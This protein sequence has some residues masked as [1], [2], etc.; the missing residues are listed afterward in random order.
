MWAHAVTLSDG[1]PSV[2]RGCAVSG[3][4][5]EGDKPAGAALAKINVNEEA[6]KRAAKRVTNGPPRVILGA[7]I[8]ISLDGSGVAL[9]PSLTGKAGPLNEPLK[10]S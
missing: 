9:G 4:A 6:P 7:W 3:L 1:F 8:G 10:G 2:S 5:C